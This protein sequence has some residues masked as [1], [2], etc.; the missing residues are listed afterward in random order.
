MQV[1][2]HVSV[3][4][5][6]VNGLVRAEELDIETIQIFGSSPR[7]WQVRQPSLEDLSAYKNQQGK[8]LV[9][10]VF[11]H[12]PYLINLATEDDGLRNKSIESLS[13]HLSIAETIQAFGLVFHVG[14]SGGLKE[15]ALERVARATLSVLER[16]PGRT[17]LIIENSAMG[18]HKLGI[19]P[20]EL[21]YLIR[22]IDHPRIGFCLDT[23]HAFE[24]GVFHFSSDR[25][26]RYISD[27]SDK[28]DWE[29]LKLL[30]SNDSATEFNSGRDWHAN[31]GEG[32]IGID[33]FRS[34]AKYDVFNSKP[35]ILEVT[36]FDNSGPD[37]ENVER[38]K[39]CFQ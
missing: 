11:L 31:I 3:A 36:G 14:S 37:R 7:Q 35:W 17:Y 8:R 38:L 20:A 30:H 18:G 6:L 16:V 32:F 12:A 29:Y 27:W 10:P 5:G 2:A 24:S 9:Q 15:K 22:M 4:G 19:S 28:I 1:G 33:G 13:G 21:G 26:E 39:S 34:L 25:I 23:A